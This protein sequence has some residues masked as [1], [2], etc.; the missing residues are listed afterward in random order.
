MDQHSHGLIERFVGRRDF[1]D[2]PEGTIPN[3]DQLALAAVWYVVFLFSTTL[4]EAAHA[5]TAR[6]YQQ[7]LWSQPA[8][9][10]MDIVIAWKVFDELFRPALLLALNLLYPE[11]GYGYG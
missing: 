10:L 1:I 3:L 7:M 11:M 4:H 9:A 6:S 2:H 5:F 8:L